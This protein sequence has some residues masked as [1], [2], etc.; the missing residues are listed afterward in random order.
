MVRFVR[1]SQRPPASLPSSVGD[2]LEDTLPALIC[3]VSIRDLTKTCYVL[4]WRKRRNPSLPI[5]AECFPLQHLQSLE[6]TS[7]RTTN[8]NWYRVF[9]IY[10]K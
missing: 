2:S 10:L 6:K 8:Q 3:R 1:W 4:Q 5:S 9:A 7:S